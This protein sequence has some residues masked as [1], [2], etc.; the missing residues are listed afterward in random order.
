MLTVLPWKIHQYA[1]HQRCEEARGASVVLFGEVAAPRAEARSSTITGT[2][3]AW[4]VLVAEV[5]MIT[6]VNQL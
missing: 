3:A 6:L 4:E 2:N 5:L 1:R